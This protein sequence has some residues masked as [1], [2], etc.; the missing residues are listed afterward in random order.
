MKLYSKSQLTVRL[1]GAVVVTALLTTGAMLFL[2]PS[3][4]V[5]PSIVDKLEVLNG[6]TVAYTNE[7][8]PPPEQLDYDYSRDEQQ[9]IDIYK[10]LNSA[11]VN[12]T[13]IS[14]GYNWFLEPVPQEQ[15]T[16][17]GMHSA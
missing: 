8:T 17:S 15:G 11:V 7:E 16:G 3:K 5:P 12:I 4:P 9:N 13:S 2:G 1:I 6:K 10:R 14:I